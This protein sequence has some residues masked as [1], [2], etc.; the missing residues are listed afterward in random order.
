MVPVR[1]I[2]EAL[3]KQVV[4][5]GEMSSVLLE[6][7]AVAENTLAA[8][9]AALYALLPATRDEVMRVPRDTVRIVPREIAERH[10]L[11]PLAV[12]GGTLLVA[13]ARPLDADVEEQLG[14]LLGFELVTRIVCDVRIS[15]ALVHH[16]AI[17]APPRHTR[18]IDKLRARD[19]GPV[20]YV[21]PPQDGKVDR[22]SL[23]HMPQKR[24]SVA[25]WLDEEDDE[26][27]TAPPP[28]T[29]IVRASQVP[30][31]RTTDP[32]GVPREVVERHVREAPQR[33]SSLPP[34]QPVGTTGKP[35]TDA[36]EQPPK[37]DPGS[38]TA[39]ALRRLR[40][41]LTAA[42]AVKLLEQAEHRDEILEV[43]FAFS[44]QFFDY[45]ALFVVHDD[46][47]DGRDAF[48]SGAGLDA[49]RRI[50][51]PLDVP[52]TFG[53][54]RRSLKP[55]V[56]RLA[57]SDLDRLVLRDLSRGA[58]T[59]ALVMPVAIRG[60]AVLMLYADRAGDSFT[61]A[62]L[63]ELVAFVP[64][65]VDAFERLILRRKRGPG[66]QRGTGGDRGGASGG[67]EPSEGERAGSERDTL[68]MAARAMAEITPVTR[69]RASWAGA[70]PT[71][72]TPPDALPVLSRPEDAPRLPDRASLRDRAGREPAQP[73]AT[74]QR[75]APVASRWESVAPPA[76]SS[77]P[78]LET[79]PSE[80]PRPAVSRT[81]SSPGLDVAALA[82]SS[83]PRSATLRSMLG[84]PRAA[85][86]PPEANVSLPP[87]SERPPPAPARDD[88][89]PELTLA[90]DTNGADSGEHD[91]ASDLTPEPP[92]SAAPRAGG[93]YIVRDAGVDVVTAAPPKRNATERPR[94]MRP[95]PRAEVSEDDVP[96]T[97]EVIHVPAIEARRQRPADS[98]PPQR[99][100][101]PPSSVES[102]TVI[103]DMG[104]QVNAMVVDLSRCG[105]DGEQAIVDSLVRM[106]EVAL[107][108]LAQAFPGPLWFDRRRPYRR[109]PRGRDVSA[110]GRALVAFRERAAPYVA[111]LLDVAQSD[112]RFYATLVAGE[113]VHPTLV[114]ALAD[115]VFDDDDGVRAAA[116]EILPRFRS[117]K[118]EWVETLAQLRRAAKIR[119]RDPEKRRRAARALGALR[120][121]G[122]VR[123]L[124]ELLDDEDQ[125]LADV[126]HRALVE[127]ACEDMGTAARRWMPW[128][129]KNERRHRIE[130]LID[131]LSHSDESIRTAAGDELKS[132]TQQYYGFHPAATRKEREVAQQKY[133]RWWEEEGARQFG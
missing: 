127:I 19:P 2:E 133:R 9:C 113:I 98:A 1:K 6:L 33:P 100:A 86:L 119:G 102:P 56:G 106:G 62:D 61:V 82:R 65:V 10:R 11:V 120:D 77:A 57:A 97:Q 109:M 124:I 92:R 79:V 110:I 49:V 89:E 83:A 60:R 93:A 26:E 115:R 95:D 4:S 63:P 114:A 38:E 16:Y 53:E 27:E 71:P 107:P 15:A 24:P 54:V 50:A 37:S 14:F 88:D 47:A 55:H 99:H 73:V 3:Q 74:P 70:Q 126:A 43:F 22:Q 66:Y 121:A 132:L 42:H 7:D 48:G 59:P 17:D 116:L 67:E 21:A 76:A 129:Q 23:S 28:S 131:A 44:R 104:D 72:S 105:P 80:P 84:I 90:Y 35:P 103:V 85:P 64:R 41:P 75:A 31:S 39:R 29:P 68:K 18:L 123:L 30:E 8:Y 111:S 5:G 81:A 69:P 125:D 20:P 96:V 46:V 118:A 94:S 130:W 40:G 91:L 12:D 52:G 32:L 36:P 25:D 87:V 108:T 45:A 112:R 122:S 13:L 117:F 51:V 78:G 128:L 101:A 34:P 58:T